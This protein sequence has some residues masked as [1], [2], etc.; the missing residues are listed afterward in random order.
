M[1]ECAT[2]DEVSTSL[3]PSSDFE[4]ILNTKNMIKRYTR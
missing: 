1:V 3:N 2:L 4:I